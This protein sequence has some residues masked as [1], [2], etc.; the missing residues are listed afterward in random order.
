MLGGDLYKPN[1]SNLPSSPKVYIKSPKSN[2]KFKPAEK[3]TNSPSVKKKCVDDSEVLDN[4]NK[5]CL[6]FKA[7]I[8]KQNSNATGINPKISING[9]QV[10]NENTDNFPIRKNRNLLTNIDDVD[11]KSSFNSKKEYADDIVITGAVKQSS[12]K[13]VKSIEE[14]KEQMRA[15]YV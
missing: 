6:S 2:S 12:Q 3:I 5:N 4:K 7:P 10:N 8:K 14:V 15:E 1:I 11:K 9:E 13:S